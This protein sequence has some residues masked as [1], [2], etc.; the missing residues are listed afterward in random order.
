MEIENWKDCA[1][2]TKDYNSKTIQKQI[3]Y[4]SKIQIEK[5][6][7]KITFITILLIIQFTQS[8]FCYQYQG[9]WQQTTIKETFECLNSIQLTKSDQKYLLDQIKEILDGY[10]YK[11]ILKNPPQPSK[12]QNYHERI[13][14]D[15]EIQ[16]IEKSQSTSYYQF[17]SSVKRMINKARDLHLSF[18]H[19]FSYD[20][21]MN[22]LQ[23]FYVYLP[24]EFRV[25]EN[26]LYLNPYQENVGYEVD[27]FLI[28]NRNRKVSEIN[29]KDP[30]LFIEEF[31]K[32]YVSLKNHH[33]R[34]TYSKVVSTFF[35]LKKFALSEEE[36]SRQI[37]IKYEGNDNV[38]TITY[39]IVYIDESKAP[40]RVQKKIQQHAMGINYSPIRW[41]DLSDEMIEERELKMNRLLKRRTYGGTDNVYCTIDNDKQMNTFV[42]TSFY[43]SQEDYE[44]YITTITKCIESFDTNSYTIQIILPLNGGGIL[45]YG[46][47]IENIF[48]PNND[49]NLISS[50]RISNLTELLLKSG[51]GTW[52]S[53]IETCKPKETSNDI[54]TLGKWYTEPI[55]VDYGNNVHHKMTQFSLME[56]S[57][58]LYARLKNNPRKPT[59][60]VVYTDAFCYSCCSI[61]TKGLKERGSA[62]IVGFEGD[63]RSKGTSLFDV[64]QSPSSVLTFS[65]IINDR[66]NNLMKRGFDM[67]F[68]FIQSFKYNYT[69]KETIPREFIV[70]EVDERVDIYSYD[71]SLIDSFTQQTKRIVNKYVNE[72]NPQNK[73]L[74]KN[75]NSCD[76]VLK[77]IDQH[78]HGG[79]ECG[80]DGKWSN[81]CVA[82]YCDYGYRFDFDNQ[83]CIPH[84]CP[85]FNQPPEYHFGGSWSIS[86]VLFIWIII[87]LM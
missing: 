65:E 59:D 44:D 80:D 37:T 19:I 6:E 42:L 56:N 7:M 46:Q 41:N 18:D 67:T 63:P 11:D 2:N 64:G 69:Y 87:L 45:S 40:K 86:I 25:T 20:L 9:Y 51:Y 30:L 16:Q 8:R 22:K 79:Y 39:R 61:L 12:N 83:K 53:D 26:G 54:Q 60:I 32:N 4:K 1:R 49:V 33:A 84:V 13:D 21:N 82:T 77:N 15:S 5:S 78:A 75:D 57:N 74:V 29:G 66:Y 14:F 50:L 36:L 43:P 52:V 27:S 81:K 47:N 48:A 31:G 71:E 34:F 76:N 73:R 35:S 17:F 38:Y 70:D 62:I 3:D 10:V 58:K 68:T 85:L 55:D 24:F 28:Q 72:C 23:K